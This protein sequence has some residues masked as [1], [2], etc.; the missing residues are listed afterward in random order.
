M[1]RLH[2]AMC[3]TGDYRGLQASSTGRCKG[4]LWAVVAEEYSYEYSSVR[5]LLLCGLGDM[6]SCRLT[7]TTIVPLDLVK[8]YMQVDP[9]KYKG[10]LSSFGVM[11]G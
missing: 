3:D 6:L 9:S 7:H 11:Y 1:T 8:C 5:Y 10:I 2:T 4:R